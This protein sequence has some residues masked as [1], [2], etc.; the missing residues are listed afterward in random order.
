MPKNVR[1]AAIARQLPQA[2]LAGNTCGMA[3]QSHRTPI[4]LTRPAAQSRRFA[5]SL[6]RAVSQPLRVTIAPLMQPIFF[7]ISTPLIAP[8]VLVFT[9]ETGVAAYAADPFAGAMMAYCVGDA[10]ARVARKQGLQA[11]SASGDA[12]DLVDLILRTRPAGP[13]LHLRGQESTGDVV[14][15]LTEAGLDA[16]DLVVYAQAPCA[17]TSAALRLLR[18]HEPV[19]L[20]LFSPRS[21]RLFCA[22]VQPTAPL[23]IAAM[24]QAVADALGHLPHIQLRI[25]AAPTAAAMVQTVKDLLTAA[26]SA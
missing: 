12:H 20:P 16:T 24:S 25:A 22:A 2:L 9:S 26:R 18:G 13:I 11:I 4:L 5:Q 3:G 19:V 14:S 15:R 17:L 6:R 1:T 8:A 7:P 21:A 23:H 10:T